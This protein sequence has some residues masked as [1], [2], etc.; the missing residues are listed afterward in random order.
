MRCWVNKYNNTNGW[1]FGDYRDDFDLF[2][3]NTIIY[4]HN[5]TNRT[6]FGSLTWALK[7]SWYKNNDNQF[8][9][10]SAIKSNTVWGNLSDFIKP[11]RANKKEC[12][13]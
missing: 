5:L 10:L 6:M 11:S 13:S 8:I 9:K 1:I 2:G 3:T 4:G 12:R 7:P